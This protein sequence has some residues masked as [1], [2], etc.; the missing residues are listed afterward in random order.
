M[1]TP[2]KRLGKATVLCGCLLVAAAA[3]SLSAASETSSSASAAAAKVQAAL[4]DMDVWLAGDERADAW[5]EYLKTDALQTELKKGRNADRQRLDEILAIYS[6]DGEALAHPRFVAVRR[7]LSDW[8]EKLSEIAPEIALKDLPA[9]I[10]KARDDFR[11]VDN[12]RFKVA[13]DA[14]RVA[15]DDLDSFLAGGG[16]KKETGWKELLK[17]S[18]LETEVEKGLSAS[19]GVLSQILARHQEGKA[20]MELS[21]FANVR[22]ALR[23]F[24]DMVAVAKDQQIERSFRDLLGKLADDVRSYIKNPRP[25]STS[26]ARSVGWSGP[27]KRPDL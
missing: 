11:P 10:E 3:G 24:I 18:E 8:R 20:G 14:L 5:N 22:M 6:R 12:Q 1:G 15:M 25:I 17:W 26:P 27:A 9:A 21:Q 7:A 19:A 13:Q 16:E 23:D 4:A 2:R